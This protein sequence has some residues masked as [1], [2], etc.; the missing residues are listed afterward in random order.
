MLSPLFS[1]FFEL[2]LK[3]V[4]VCV[5]VLVCLVVAMGVSASVHRVCATSWYVV[6]VDGVKFCSSLVCIA[7][8]VYFLLRVSWGLCFFLFF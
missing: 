5:P 4:C 1:L 8:L 2:G 7:L 6:G 3:C